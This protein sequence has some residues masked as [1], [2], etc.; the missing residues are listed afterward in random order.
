MRRNTIFLAWV[1]LAVGVV[2]PSKGTDY[3]FCGLYSTLHLPCPACGMT[4]SVSSFLHGHWD[5]S[6]QFHPMGG[7]VALG[8]LA[9]AGASF[10][11][12]RWRESARQW[13]TRHER[14]ALWVLYS[15]IALWLL[16]GFARIALVISGVWQ[17]PPA[18]NP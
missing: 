5:W 6:W 18:L 11:P 3:S 4:R 7:I 15:L 14:P 8:L 10:W 17:F 1:T 16:Y 9:V 13:L 2:L 12:E